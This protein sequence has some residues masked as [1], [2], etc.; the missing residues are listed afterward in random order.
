MGRMIRMRSVAQQPKKG[1]PLRY[2]IFWD[3]PF[4]LQSMID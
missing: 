3:T 1:R 4:L 2:K